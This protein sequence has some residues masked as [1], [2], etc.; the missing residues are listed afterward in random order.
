MATIR[1]TDNSSRTLD[2][3]NNE[4][5]DLEVIANVSLESLHEKYPNLLVF[6]QSFGEFGDNLNSHH[7]CSF[8]N[9]TIMTGN[10]MGFVGYN[11]TELSISSRFCEK[12]GNDYFLHFILQKVL[13]TY[14]IEWK[15]SYT[16][17]SILDF[18]VYLFPY[19]F[20]KAL[21]QGVYREYQKK[22]HNDSKVNGPIDVSRHIQL[23]V[24]FN[25]KISY[26][27]REYSYDNR[28]T[29]LIRHTI[30]YIKTLPFGRNL[31]IAQETQNNIRLIMEN[32][33]SYSHQDLKKILADNL[34]EVHHPYYTE[35]TFLQRICLQILRHEGLKYEEHTANQIYGILF[36]GAWLWEEYVATLLQQDFNHFTSGNSHFKLLECNNEKKQK[37]IPD[38]I[39]KN[40]KI[41]AD[42]KYI[43][44]NKNSNY[45]EERA[46]AIYYKTIMY[47]LRFSS[48]YGFLFFPCRNYF[49]SKK[50]VII[51]TDNYLIEYPF[52]ISEEQ[53]QNYSAYC[54]QM[55]EEEKRFKT[56]I[57]ELINT[58]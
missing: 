35:Y 29:E 10:L 12:D 8:S 30:E 46:T 26:S 20:N 37:I 23:N 40:R 39:S 4:I 11:S 16:Q 17:T 1:L 36:D 41:V 24:P 48:K 18:L 38:Y 33:P 5:S 34:R 47:M 56:H 31:L 45:G 2:L 58:A 22:N 21:S 52:N 55:S 9:K 28:I 54:L 15:H 57:W 6:P 42:A 3:S 7:I 50:Y 25:G 43:P 32:T 27:T 44:L 13:C 49:E 19:F 51:D 53:E 14:I